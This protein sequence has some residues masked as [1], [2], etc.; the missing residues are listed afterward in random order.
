MAKNPRPG[1]RALLD[2]A[3]IKA[4]TS[5]H[6]GFMLGPRI[7]AAGRLESAQAALDLLTSDDY[8]TAKRLAVKLDEINLERRKTQDEIVAQARSAALLQIERIQNDPVWNDLKKQ[9]QIAEIGP[10]P[11]AL[12]LCSYDLDENLQPW[13]EGVVGIV[14][15]KIVEEFSRPVFILSVK[16]SNSESQAAEILKGSI[17]SIPKID[18][19]A[20]ISQDRVRKHLLN[21]G[22]HAHA[23]GV[24]LLRSELEAFRLSLNEYML[25]STQV[26]DYV[27]ENRF[28]AELELSEIDPRLLG[29]LKKLE[30]FGHG[31]PDPIFKIVAKSAQNV[32][33]LKEKHLKLSFKHSSADVVWFNSVRSENPLF[34]LSALERGET[35][36]FWVSPQWNDFQGVKRLQLQVKHAQSVVVTSGEQKN[37]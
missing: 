16:H 31:F 14:A 2:V 36:D 15:S 24:T 35:F 30:P 7:N 3:N 28:D 27:R 29:E 1:I 21:F 37:A 33:V 8:E 5:M 6:C 19:L 11:R 32:R 12:V 26:T 9:N 25:Q 10:W 20:Q 34:D 23:G 18:I 17:R 22:G 4:P 13:H